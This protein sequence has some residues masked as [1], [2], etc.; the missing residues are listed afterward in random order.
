M[1]KLVN[2]DL[3]FPTHGLMKKIMV[4]FKNIL[5]IILCFCSVYVK[6]QS[7]E[8]ISF[9]SP[10]EVSS[11]LGG[12]LTVDIKYTSESGATS[13]NFYIGL[14]ELDENN[15]FVSTIDG[16]DFVNQTAGTNIS[17]S[18]NLFVGTIHTL[19]NELEAGHYY[20][21]TAKIYT[22]TWNELASADYTNTPLLIIQNTNPYNFTSFPITKGA[23]ISSMT[24]M[25]SEGVSWQDNDGNPRQLMP[26]LKDYDLNAVRLR[27]WVDPDNS[28]ANGW[29]DIDDMVTKAQLADAEGLDIMICTHFSDHWADPG[30]QT[31]PAA[32][33]NFS[34]SQLETAVANHITDILNALAAVNIS[35]KWVQIGNETNDGML[36][37][38]GKASTG[39]FSNYAKFINA[40]S[41]AVKT[42]DASIKT[43]LHLSNGHE[44]G[45]YDW[46]IGGLINNGLN[47]N[48]ID[49]IGMS[50]YPQE[51]NWKVLV[52][53]TYDNMINIKNTYNKDTMVVEIG[54]SNSRP[55]ITYQYIVYMIE[56]VRQAQGLGVFYWEPIAHQPFTFY[57]NGAWDEDGSPSVAMDAF[58]DSSTTLNI[59]NVEQN[60]L[61]L[62]PN[63]SSEQLNIK[64]KNLKLINFK[65]YNLQ[66]HL[67]KSGDFD[68]NINQRS[69]DIH[70]I[71]SGVYLLRIN[72][73]VTLKFIKK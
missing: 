9:N 53:Q 44:Q 13:N 51:N 21:I 56:R 58:L 63:P 31:K 61:D 49:I 54:F 6:A 15:Q 16:V 47:S 2:L 19:S 43:I 55:D 52:D 35:P 14:Q 25:E 42:F 8:I 7:I 71:N 66:G 30:Q 48:N 17:L 11:L 36:W 69:I 24:E 40:G 18:T 26:L 27:V 39:G 20:Q 22:N 10:L 12:E 59:S 65:I 34:V 62:F 73:L 41:N 45:M 72:D 3:Y 60:T 23:D 68:D 28:P 33:V 70:N 67:I 50:L 46:N 1:Q 4:K 64:I 5:F 57:P 32:W 38:T 29:C 37:D